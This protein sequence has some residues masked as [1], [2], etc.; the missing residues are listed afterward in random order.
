MRIVAVI[1]ARFNSSRLPGK[2]LIDINGKTMLQRVHDNAQLIK[3]VDKIIVAT[4]DQRIIDHCNEN[5]IQSI[6]TSS[7]HNTMISRVAEVSNS[8]EA[9]YFLVLNGDEPLLEPENV[10]KILFGLNKRKSNEFLV[11]NLIAPIDIT[12]LLDDGTDLMVVVNKRNHVIYVSRAH[13]P[14]FKHN[15]GKSYL[16]HLGCYLLTRKSL[17]FFINT[18]KGFLESSEDIDLLRYIE[19]H[20]RVEAVIVNSKSIS[21]DLKED[22]KIVSDI[23]RTQS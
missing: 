14:K 2:P 13:I 19:N 22:I 9:D 1:P 21:V 10:N 17:E 16:K 12:K 8:I 18:E 7:H 23:L 11:R 5:S 6:L 4:E 3:A 20:K 15:N